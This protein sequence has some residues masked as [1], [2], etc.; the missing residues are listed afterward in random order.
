MSKYVV[1][2]GWDHAPHLS[3]RA[4]AELLASIPPYQREA[5]T[6]GIPTLGSGAIYPVAESDFVITPVELAP[7]WRRGFGLD[8]GFNRTACIW[9]AHDRDT[10]TLYLYSEHY[11]GRMDAAENARHIRAKGDWIPGVIDPAARGRSQTDGQQLLQ[12]YVDQGLDLTTA[13]NSVEAGI[14]RVWM[15]LVSGRLKV[16]S[17]LTNWLNEFRKYRRDENGRVVKADDHAMDATRYLE[18]SGLDRMVS[19]LRRQTPIIQN[20]GG[21]V[22]AG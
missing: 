15:R 22:F 1:Q 8:V 3:E 14:D 6:K 7:H 5:R 13:D 17:S 21:R 11:G 18:V 12:N 20:R 9:G 16:F 10:D 2:A 19:P 4:K